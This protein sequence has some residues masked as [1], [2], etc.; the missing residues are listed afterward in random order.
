M[1]AIP[2]E[3]KSC[4]K[5]LSPADEPSGTPSSR[6]CVPEAPSSTPLPPLS[7]S[8]PRSSF[9]AVSNCCVVFAWPNSYSRANFR[10]MFR[11]RTNARAP[12]RVSG[13]MALGAGSCSSLRFPY[14]TS[15][16][17]AVAL[18]VSQIASPLLPADSLLSTLVSPSFRHKP[19]RACCTHLN[20]SFPCQFGNIVAAAAN[21]VLHS[22]LDR[23]KCLGR[24]ATL[25]AV[26]FA[27]S[28]IILST[29]N[30][31]YQ[32]FRDRRSPAARDRRSRLGRD[33][34]LSPF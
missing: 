14:G 16:L 27:G 4:A 15:P 13:L 3:V 32:D 23:P 17:S 7:S 22:M 6:I 34:R 25:P 21:F 2:D 10:R 18:L 31:W 26:S 5:L 8:A 12:P 1:L 24:I 33:C 28:P 19:P 9:H 30:R 11:L 29:V 20:N